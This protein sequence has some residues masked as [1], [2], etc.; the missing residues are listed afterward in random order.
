MLKGILLVFLGACSYGVLS[1]FVKFAYQDGYT[2]GDITGTQAFFGAIGLWLLFFSRN[3]MLKKP[4][5]F[6]EKTPIYQLLLAGICSGCVSIFYYQSVKLVPNSIAII[7]LMQFIWIGI[8]LEYFIFKKKI[9]TVQVF[10]ILSVLGGTALASGVFA[11]A[12]KT[13][14]TTGI[15]YGLLAAVCYAGFI[16]LNGRLG[17]DYRPIKK[18]A[19]MVTGSCI[20]IFI[21]FPPVF[22]INGALSGSLF[23]WGLLIALFGTVIPPLCYAIGVP[24]TGLA[25]SSILSAAELPIAVLL[26]ALFLHEHVSAGR[27]FGVA[28]IL[29][30]IAISNLKQLLRSKQTVEKI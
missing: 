26:S 20:F 18:A 6:V 12:L 9:T 25:L 10:S 24:K 22:L 29:S 28:V 30:A 2:L 1:T 16:M 4:H 7:L 17:N 15:V 23:K 11:S 21:I 3:A 14:N 5:G 27:W 19:L 8:L 13:I